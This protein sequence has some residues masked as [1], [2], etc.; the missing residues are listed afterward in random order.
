MTLEDFRRPRSAESYDVT[1]EWTIH[2]LV[3][4]EA[5]HRGE[6]ATIRSLAEASL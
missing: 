6:M 5:E 3:L 2:H 4:H 1:P